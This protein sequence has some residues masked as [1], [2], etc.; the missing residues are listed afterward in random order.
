[1][2]RRSLAK[3][4]KGGR[5]SANASKKG[6]HKMVNGK[7]K[8]GKTKRGGG[9]VRRRSRRNRRR[10][11]RN[12]RKGGAMWGFGSTRP[13]SDAFSDPES[14]RELV[15]KRE[16]SPSMID[17]GLQSV[18]NLF[19]SSSGNRQGRARGNREGMTERDIRQQELD[20]MHDNALQSPLQ[21]Q[22]P[23]RHQQQHQHHQG[24]RGQMG[25]R[26]MGDLE[27]A[28]RRQNVGYGGQWS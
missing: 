4:H 21:H 10:S 16:R 14:M 24:F 8:N 6:G 15:R 12:R 3:T 2:A 23:H 28:Q 1:M 13:R 22:H 19:G 26:T 9:K 5:K 25:S 7:S 18:G 27:R 11:R 17:R 20:E